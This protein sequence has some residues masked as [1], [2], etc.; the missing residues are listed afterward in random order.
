MKQVM[1][2]YKVKAD[3]VDENA[4]LVRAVYEELE[5]VAPEGFQYATFRLDDGQTFVHLALGGTRDA[6]LPQLE[7]F[8][9]FQERLSERVVEGPVV[10]EISQVGSYRLG[11]LA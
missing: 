1:V 2:R 3:R 4:D 5:S 8:R 11:P 10:T 7:A 6:P 9:R